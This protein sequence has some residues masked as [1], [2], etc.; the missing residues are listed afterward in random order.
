MSHRVRIFAD[1]SC[2]Y[3]KDH[4]VW[5]QHFERY[6]R[7]VSEHGLWCQECRGAGGEVVPILDDGTGPTEYCGWCEGTGKVTR[8]IRGM[9]LRSKREH[10][11]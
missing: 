3:A 4:W 2:D 1:G 10:W 11:E 6:K 5:R 7:Y 8:W 9:W